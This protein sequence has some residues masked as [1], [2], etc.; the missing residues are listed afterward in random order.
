MI[1][2]LQ[3]YPSI[4]LA[5]AY[6]SSEKQQVNHEE[7]NERLI[8]YLKLFSGKSKSSFEK[9][10]RWALIYS[11]SSLSGD[12]TIFLNHLS[13]RKETVNYVEFI[14]HCVNGFKI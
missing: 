9:C 5:T 8:V 2:Y 12:S 1:Y 4:E 6:Y 13:D 11:D 10:L 3:L 14:V 7:Q